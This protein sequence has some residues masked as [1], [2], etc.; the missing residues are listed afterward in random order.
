MTSLTHA[1]GRHSRSDPCQL[2]S[3]RQRRRLAAAEGR[4]TCFTACSRYAR[5]SSRS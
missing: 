1:D 5:F 2:P 3:G 4:S